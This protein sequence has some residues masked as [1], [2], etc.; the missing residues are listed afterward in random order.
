MHHEFIHKLFL[1]DRMDPAR[2]VRFVEDYVATCS[3]WARQLAEVDAKFS[4]TPHGDYSES[5]ACQL[6]ALRHLRRLVDCEI[7]SAR[8]ILGELVAAPAGPRSAPGPQGRRALWLTELTMVAR[9]DRG[10]GDG[11]AGADEA[12]RTGTEP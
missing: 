7:V 9:D 2:R 8:D 4:S 6:L 1:L 11:G 12:R 3:A 10:R 5:A